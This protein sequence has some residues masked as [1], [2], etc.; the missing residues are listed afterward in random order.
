M[1]SIGSIIYDDYIFIWKNTWGVCMIKREMYLSQI[2]QLMDSDFIKVI[3]GLRRCG[4]TSLLK[5]IIE[6]LQNIGVNEDNI[7]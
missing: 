1:L 5:S 3:V 7:I 2:R 6:E 4:K